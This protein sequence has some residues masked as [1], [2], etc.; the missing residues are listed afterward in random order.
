MRFELGG[1]VLFKGRQML[2][3]MLATADLKGVLKP[4][5]EQDLI[6]K[7]DDRG[8]KP[9]ALVALGLFRTRRL[10]FDFIGMRLEIR[11]GKPPLLG[12][13]DTY[14]AKDIWIIDF[15]DRIIRRLVCLKEDL[16]QPF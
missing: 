4:L 5:I 7:V 1:H 16:R 13:L 10:P 8:L 12:L 14:D 6:L 9:G 3:L 11:I 2:R 15:E